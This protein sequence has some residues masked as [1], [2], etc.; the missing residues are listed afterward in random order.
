MRLH[1]LDNYHQFCFSMPIT[2][3]SRGRSAKKKETLKTDP[4]NDFMHSRLYCRN[5]SMDCQAH[6]PISSTFN[7]ILE[8]KF[9]G[10]YSQYS[11]MFKKSNSR[12][13]SFEEVDEYLNKPVVSFLLYYSTN[14]H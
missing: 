13:T 14:F 6:V 11:H 7:E 3:F 9:N 2:L 12:I 10:C 4:D 5:K 8:K 1:L